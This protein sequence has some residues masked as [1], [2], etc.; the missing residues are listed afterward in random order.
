VY[1]FVIHQKTYS[2]HYKVAFPL[3]RVFLWANPP[4]QNFNPPNWKS[5]HYKSGVFVKILDV[6]P[7]CANLKTLIEDFLTMVL[8][9]SVEDRIKIVIHLRSTWMADRIRY[10]PVVQKQYF[11]NILHPRQCEKDRCHPPSTFE[12]TTSYEL[13]LVTVNYLDTIY[14]I[15]HHFKCF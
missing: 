12:T 15:I 4:K 2:F 9:S 6:K 11:N 3:P 1:P 7:P 14:C 10:I 5:K 13:I 8:Q